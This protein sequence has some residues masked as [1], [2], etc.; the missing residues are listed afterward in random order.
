MEELGFILAVGDSSVKLTG[1]GDDARVLIDLDWS[2]LLE[3][4]SSVR[5]DAAEF[6]FGIPDLPALDLF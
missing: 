3:L 1:G 4:A 6:D 5:N 2:E